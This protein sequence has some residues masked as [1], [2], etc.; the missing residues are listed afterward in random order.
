M[1]EQVEI[2]IQD[3]HLLADDKF[4][5]L[6]EFFGLEKPED[7]ELHK[8]VLEMILNWA[9]KE[10]QSDEAI[11]ILLHIRSV[12]RMF[13]KDPSENRLSRLKRYIAL[14]EDQER[15]DKEMQLLT[16]K[17]EESDEPRG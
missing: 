15:V 17:Q 11:D 1:A 4:L 2:P 8:K 12:E 16:D 7:R 3:V 6:G 13:R 10:S 9:R 5:R 14:K